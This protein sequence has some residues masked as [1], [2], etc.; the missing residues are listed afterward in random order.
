MDIKNRHNF[1]DG[2]PFQNKTLCQFTLIQSKLS[3]PSKLDASLLGRFA[4]VS[5]H[6]S[7]I[8]WNLP[9]ASRIVSIVSSKSRVDRARRSSFQTTMM[10]CSRISSSIRRNSGRLRLLRKSSP[11]RFYGTTPSS[12]PGAANQDFGHARRKTQTHLCPRHNRYTSSSAEL[13]PGPHARLFGV[14]RVWRE[15]KETLRF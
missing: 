2:L 1:P 11:K 12:E 8:D 7:E 9:P 6:G 10:S 15:P 5:A 14:L 13:I 3:Q 4:P